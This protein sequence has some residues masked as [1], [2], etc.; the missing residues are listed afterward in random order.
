VPL[1]ILSEIWNMSG[2]LIYN[3]L[4]Q[5]KATLLL[6]TDTSSGGLITLFSPTLCKQFKSQRL[7]LF[8]SMLSL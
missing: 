6:S 2:D 8:N 1:I 7:L 4:G 5:V 3:S